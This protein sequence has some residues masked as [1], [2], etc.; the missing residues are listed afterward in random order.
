MTKWVG[1][2]AYVGWGLLC[3]LIFVHLLFPYKALGRRI[4]YTLEQKTNL[5]CRSSDAGAWFLGIHWDRVELSPSIQEAFPAIEIRNWVI[6]IRPLSL[7]FG[8]LSVTSHGTVMDGPFVMD[9][10]FDR[11]GYQGLGTWNGVKI[12]DFPL[13][14]MGQGSFRG[15]GSGQIRW[16]SVDQRLSGDASFEVRE[17]S[18]ENVLLSGLTLPRL[19]LGELKGQMTW[20]GER[21]ALRSLSIVGGDLR[22]ELT[23]NVLFQNPF[24]KSK[25][26]GRLEVEFAE[27]L[28]NRY[29]VMK[30]L[31]GDGQ[32]R[33][34]PIMMRIGGTVEALQVSLT[35]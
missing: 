5:V 7:V 21:I 3:V 16:E 6:Q 19:D 15:V 22:A 33:A 18:V 1:W 23:G 31:H 32:G 9:L 4:L 24:I 20:E 34:G 28:V 2:L 12:E 17:V 14:V 11:K 25:V 13:L 35:R 30:A 10:L 26:D 27:T 8:R 29:P